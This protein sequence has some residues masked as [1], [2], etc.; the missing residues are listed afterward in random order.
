SPSSGLRHCT[1]TYVT[2]QRR[3]FRSMVVGDDSGQVRITFRPGQGGADI[4]PGQGH[5]SLSPPGNYARGR[6][7]MVVRASASDVT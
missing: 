1:R 5:Q 7:S 4:Q 2:K 6:S 3:T